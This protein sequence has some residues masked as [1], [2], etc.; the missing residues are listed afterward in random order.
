MQR[1]LACALIALLPSCGASPAEI[2][3]ES[4]GSSR[5]DL[6]GLLG[7]D[8]TG[9]TRITAARPL[10]FPADHAPHQGVQT[11]WWY[12]TANLEDEQGRGLGLHFT[13]FRNALRPEPPVR[14]SDLAAAHVWMGHLALSDLDAGEHRVHERFARE[15]P[16]LAGHDADPWRVYLE[17][18]ELVGVEGFGESAGDPLRPGFR[19]RAGHGDERIELELTAAKPLVLQGDRGYSQKGPEPGNASL[20]YSATRLEAAGEW[21]IGGR[22]RSVRGRAWLDREWSTSVLPAGTVGWDWLSLQ[23]SDGRELM[24]YQLRT[25]AGEPSEY[26]HGT[27]IDRD[28]S[29]RDLAPDAFEFEPLSTWTSPRSGAS[30]PTVWR[31]RV[32]GAGIDL[33]IAARLDDQELDVTVRYWEGAVEAL[34]SQGGERLGL[35]F[36]ELTGY[37][38]P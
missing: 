34:D 38:R 25:S 28:G 11:E 26:S 1:S 33:R 6:E 15:V 32:P 14:N 10:E 23:L 27:L 2:A 22:T 17:D 3:P 20:Y 12:V 21:T 37:E 24:L 31:A 4:R 30:Y 19:L 35:G 7:G 8:A 36:L 9:F 13:L 5:L 18:W 29:K 16:G